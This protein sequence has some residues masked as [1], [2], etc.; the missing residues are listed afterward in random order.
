MIAALFVET[1]GAY[2][3]LEDVD[4]WDESRDARLYAGPWPVVAHPP[5]NRWAKL[6]RK[7][8]RGQD[9][10]CFAAALRAVRT[11]G[12]IL[13]HPA[14]TYAWR[15]FGLPRPSG[16]WWTRGLDSEGWVCAIDQWHYGFPT[17]KPTWLYYVGSQ[18]PELPD[19]RVL[20]TRGCDA[21]WST[22]RAHT[23]PAF[24]DL[25][26]AAALGFGTTDV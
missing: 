1:G 25:L 24:R 16:P 2:F 4:P 17:R 21:L 11:Y 20:A 3:G 8:L 19:K 6:G 26:I 22:E 23:P 14:E 5:C 18:P 12:G 13:E 15:K 7:E 9:D 10:G